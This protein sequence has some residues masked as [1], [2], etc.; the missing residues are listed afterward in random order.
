MAAPIVVPFNFNPA[1]TSIKAA[2]YTIPTGKYAKIYNTG[3]WLSDSLGANPTTQTKASPSIQIDGEP[4]PSSLYLQVTAT[5]STVAT[6]TITYPNVEINSANIYAFASS[7][8]ASNPLNVSI[9]R[10]AGSTLTATGAGSSGNASD[11]NAS[12]T[13]TVIFQIAAAIISATTYTG[14]VYIENSEKKDFWIPSGTVIT[15]PLGAGRYI[16]E[17][18]NQ[19][20]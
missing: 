4:I 1:S 15:I 7:N 20:S 14:R 5:S 8:Q 13:S 12:F 17:E 2:S 9:T 16:L 19:I 3:V 18:Y 10:F 11:S 6:R